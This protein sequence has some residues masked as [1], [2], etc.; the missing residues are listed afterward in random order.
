M[1]TLLSLLLA[2]PALAAEPPAY[3]DDRSD[4]ASLIRSYYNA[5]ARQEYARAYSYLSQPPDYQ[6][7][8]AGYA[9][10]ASVELVTGNVTSEGAAGSVYATVPVALRAMSA[11]GTAKLYAGC[12]VTR[13]VQAAIQD[14]PFQPI[15]IDSGHLAP[16][17]GELKAAVPGKC[18]EDAGE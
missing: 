4:P 18:P 16:A 6:T 1:W 17:T 10:T 2:T 5:I 7:F 9:D 11:D 8:S 13:Q 3:L 12:Y 15:Q 14:P